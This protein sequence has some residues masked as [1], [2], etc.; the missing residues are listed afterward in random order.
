MSVP[1]LGDL[2]T[3]TLPRRGWEGGRPEPDP[4]H[5]TAIPTRPSTMGT[6][7]LG[8]RRDILASFNNKSCH[9]S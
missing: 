5:R 8:V 3:L 7:G 2:F 9:V 4:I 1:H 6:G